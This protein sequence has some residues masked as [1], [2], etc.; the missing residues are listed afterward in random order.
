MPQLKCPRCGE[1]LASGGAGSH[2]PRCPPGAKPLPRAKPLVVAE[3]PNISASPPIP[4]IIQATPRNT[5]ANVP[6]PAATRPWGAAVWVA[7]AVGGGAALG[8]VVLVAVLLLMAKKPSV[9]TTAKAPP[10]GPVATRPKPARA[11]SP[12]TKPAIDSRPG[13]TLAPFLAPSPPPAEQPI[14]VPT[15]PTPA[16]VKLDQPPPVVKPKAFVL[17]EV[18]REKWLVQWPR[19]DRLAAP[20]EASELGSLQRPNSRMLTRVGISPNG[21]LA[22]YASDSK[23]SFFDLA[24]GEEL[25]ELACGPMTELSA[26]WS[27]IARL[28]NRAIVLGPLGQKEGTQVSF[29]AHDG[30]SDIRLSPDGRYLAIGVNVGD[31][32]QPGRISHVQLWQVAGAKRIA[33]IEKKWKN[34][35]FS[36]D[37]RYLVLGGGNTFPTDLD[38]VDLVSTTDGNIQERIQIVP[39]GLESAERFSFSP[40]GSALVIVGRIHHPPPPRTPSGPTQLIV[41][42]IAKKRVRWRQGLEFYNQSVVIARYNHSW[43]AD[44]KRLLITSASNRRGF[45]CKTVYDGMTGDELMLVEDCAAAAFAP[46]SKTL[47]VATRQVDY[48][49]DGK[50]L[51]KHHHSSFLVLHD[52]ASGDILKWRPLNSHEEVGMTYSRDGSVLMLSRTFPDRTQIKAIDLWDARDLSVLACTTDIPERSATLLVTD[53][54]GSQ[55]ISGGGDGS[56]RF[57][58]SATGEARGVFGA[59]TAGFRSL[60]VSPDGSKLAWGTTAGE[61]FVCDATQMK[62]PVLLEPLQEH[63]NGLFFCDEGKKLLAVSRFQTRM[64]DLVKGTTLKDVELHARGSSYTAAS[65]DGK[66]LASYGTGPTYDHFGVWSLPTLKSTLS[67]DKTGSHME[68]LAVSGDGKYLA[69]ADRSKEKETILGD[70]KTGKILTRIPVVTRAATPL[71]FT[72]DGKWLVMC[73]EREGSSNR[74]E[75]YEVPSGEKVVTLEGHPD[76]ITGVA[77]SP[78]KDWLVSVDQKCEMRYWQLP[79]GELKHSHSSRHAGLAKMLKLPPTK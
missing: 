34:F 35:E 57:W 77:V 46:D 45:P 5:S 36:P 71:Q 61:I 60:T 14:P 19:P 43:S 10:R 42:D 41:W 76:Y 64:Y 3:S 69:M 16:E 8:L 74:I 49:P 67:L 31:N 52:L 2:C 26:D 70:A 78:D 63:A 28:E 68:A 58:D 40:D 32:P 7:G 50:P 11:S 72:A 18:P 21:R 56:L 59:S 23:V 54:T 73:A 62:I 22:A 51:P 13:S 1:P 9:R 39:L 6:K 75:I 47:A 79:S 20:L 48:T 44:S 30:A 66:V 4:P 65:R 29:A 12:A 25:Q 15:Q 27:T 55:V 37:S 17:P 33:S 38:T 24:T 53:P